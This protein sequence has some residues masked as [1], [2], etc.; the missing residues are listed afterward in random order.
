VTFGRGP[1]SG[2][3]FASSNTTGGTVE[4][5]IGSPQGNL[6][7]TAEIPNTGGWKNFSTI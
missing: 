1:L 3:I 7:A 2:Q 5:R 4:F 6:I